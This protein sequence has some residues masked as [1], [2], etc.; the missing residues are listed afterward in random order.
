MS[1][2]LIIIL[3]AAIGGPLLIA[4]LFK[5][6]WKVPRADEALIVTGF[7]V[8]GA[9]ARRADVEIG[10]DGQPTASPAAASKTFK[11]ITGGGAFVIPA[12][13]K[14]QYLRCRQARRS[15]RS[16]ASTSATVPP[17]S[18][19]F[20]ESLPDLRRDLTPHQPAM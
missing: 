20:W 5:T 1:T 19:M 6:L 15:S 9:P 18:T 12:L 3:V 17:T 8:K 2:D 13:Q 16:R 4:I 7:G 14:A 10:P 11:I